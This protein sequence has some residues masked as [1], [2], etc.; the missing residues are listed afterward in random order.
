[1]VAGIAV[2]AVLAFLLTQVTIGSR[3]AIPA[4]AE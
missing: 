2:C 4:A 1:M 3:Q